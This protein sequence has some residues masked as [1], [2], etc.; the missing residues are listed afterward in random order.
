MNWLK[1]AGG[2][3][4]G[5]GSAARR[6][7][8]TVE[9]CEDRTL[10]A[11]FVVVNSDDS[12]D[13]S[14]RQA[15]LD[16]NEQ[17]G[18]D[19]ITFEAGLSAIQLAT[20][21]DAIT[22][23]VSINSTGVA[24]VAIDG[25]GGAFDGLTLAAGSGG[26]TI[27]LLTIRNLGGAAIRVQTDG[28]EIVGNT[29]GATAGAVA[30]GVLVDGGANNTIG[31]TG[32]G[33]ANVLGFATTAGV[34]LF[35]A[36][37][38]GNL[39]RGN[40]IGV[41]PAGEAIGNQ[42]GV[43]VFDAPG[44]TIG[45]AGGGNLIGNSAVAGVLIAGAGSTGNVVAA[46]AFGATVGG[47]AAPNAYGVQIN[48]ASGNT[49]G[50][51]GGLGN[52]ID[53]STSVG[54]QVFGAAATENAILG[55]AIGLRGTTDALRNGFGVEINAAGGNTVGGAA[56]G[57][58]NVVVLA[59]T[60]GVQVVG[61]TPS[62]NAVIG[63]FIG[64]DAT[65]S[66]GLGNTYG[67]L[68][69]NSNDNS[70]GGTAAGQGNTVGFNALAGVS[71]LTG[72]RNF[73]LNNRYVGPNGTAPTPDPAAD[74]NVGV[75]ANGGILPPSL[76]TASLEGAVLRL[77]FAADL[78]VGTT[79]QVYTLDA[80][81]PGRRAF[82]GSG[83]IQS[84]TEDQ[85][86]IPAGSLTDS[87]IVLVT[88]SGAST[89]TS[90]FSNTASVGDL[91]TVTTNVGTDAGSLPWVIA[92][93]NAG[94]GNEIRFD[95]DPG[96]RTI[97]VTAAAPL[98]AILAPVTTVVPAGVRISIQASGSTTLFNGLTLGPGSDGSVV[99]RM[100]FLGFGG[101]GLRVQSGTG[102]IRDVQFDGNGVGLL[103]EGAGNTA[104]GN[105][106]IRSSIAGVQ[107]N[108]LAATGNVIRGN[109]IGSPTDAALGNAV[110]VVI[111]GASG[112]T[113]GEAG[114]PNVIANNA[115]Q[116]VSI[117]AGDRNVVSENGYQSNGPA[118]G[119]SYSLAN[120]LVVAPGSNQ[121]IQP[122]LLL[123]ATQGLAGLSLLVELDT[124]FASPPIL[125]VYRITATTAEFL[126]RGP[127]GF[128]SG[129]GTASLA[130]TGVLPGDRLAVAV[131][132]DVQEEGTNLPGDATSA[133]SNQVIVVTPNVVVNTN[134]DGDGS[135]RGAVEY[136]SSLPPSADHR[137][138][139]R[140]P[141]ELKDPSGDWVIHLSSDIFVSGLAYIDGW[142][143]GES[144]EPLPGAF[145][146]P[147]VYVRP[148]FEGDRAE[149]GLLFLP[150]S[151]GSL[152]RGL[153]FQAFATAA[154]E[155][156][157][158]DVQVSGNVMTGALAGDGPPPTPA[159]IGVAITGGR[160][161]LVGGAAP[162]FQ[163]VLGGFAAAVMVTQGAGSNY[164]VGNQIGTNGFVD[165]RNYDGVLIFDSADNL[166]LNNLIGNSRYLAAPG[167]APPES[168]LRA[169]VRIVGAGATRNRVAGNSLGVVPFRDTEVRVGNDVGVYVGAPG[170]VIGSLI[171]AA[172]PVSG[173]QN[174]I[175]RNLH[176][177]L[178]SA[179]ATG[180]V[181]AGNYIGTDAFNRQLGNAFNGVWLRGASSNAVGVADEALANV[182]A[183]NSTGV[184]LDA[185]AASNA[186]ANNFIGTNRQ[187]LPMPNG[188][189]VL[190][191]EA[192]DTRVG[193][194][195]TSAPAL[196]WDPSGVLLLGA[197][198]ISGN[199]VGIRV[200]SV[201][202]AGNR[203]VG[204]LIG[205]YLGLPG[206]AGDGVD[207]IGIAGVTLGGAARPA[208]SG[209]APLTPG[210]AN[211]ISGNFDGVYVGPGAVGELIEGNWIFANRLNGVRVVSPMGGGVSIA[212]IRGN[213]IGTTF[214]GSSNRTAEGAPTGNGLS[215]VLM[216][217][218][219]SSP[220][221]GAWSVEVRGNLI[222]SNGLNGVTVDPSGGE[223][224]YAEGGEL[225]R[226]A[227]VLVAANTI[228]LSLAGAAAGGG[229][230]FGNVLDGV[231]IIGVGGV[232]VGEE[233]PAGGRRW[234]NVISGN[235]G[236]GVEVFWPAGAAPATSL[237]AVLIVGNLIGAG[238]EGTSAEGAAL[239][240][241]N[242][243][244][245]VFL[246][247][248]ARA[249]IRRNRIVGNRGAGVHAAGASE[250][251][252]GYLLI[253]ENEIG[254]D[255]A[256]ADLGNSADG[257]IVDRLA[258]PFAASGEVARI[259][260]NVI[261]ANRANGITVQAS[262]DVGVFGNLIGSIGLIAGSAAD[263][264]NLGNGVFLNGAIRATVGGAGDDG[265]VISG[266]QGN[267][268]VMSGGG[269]NELA[270]NHIGVGLDGISAVGN[271]NSGVLVS[272]SSGNG[273]GL[274]ADGQVVGNVVSGNRLYGVLIV[275]G[276][277]AAG[278]NFV[279]GNRVGVDRTG[280][281]A[282]PNSS[283]GLFL[284]NAA[285][286]IVGGPTAASRNIISGNDAQGVRVFG[287]A[288]TG[289][290]IGG[291]YIGVGA[292]GATRI[293]N[294]G[295]GLIL[296]NAGPNA[297]GL[298]RGALAGNVI[299]GNAQ[300]GI[301]VAST[302]G[303]ASGARIVANRI[304]LDA[305][306]STPVGNGGS[307]VVLAGAG[308]VVI[309]GVGPGERNWI[310]ANGQTGVVVSGPA[311]AGAPA[312]IL[313]NTIGLDGEGARPL[314][315]GGSGVQIVGA[316]GVEVGYNVVSA[317]AVDGVQVFS[318][319]ARSRADG[320]RIFGNFI[321]TNLAGTAALG[322]RGVGV[323]LVN[324]HGNLVGGPTPNVIS[325]NGAHGVAID[326]Q[327]G[328]GSEGVGNVVD[329]NLIGLDRGGSYRL[330]NGLYGVLLNN[331][332]GTVVGY[333][334][335]VP[336]LP[337]V[338]GTLVPAPGAAS[339]VISGNGAAGIVMTGS[340]QGTRVRG[341]YI[342]V[343]ALGR[344]YDDAGAGLDLYNRVGVLVE[345]RASGNWIGGLIDGEEGRPEGTGNLITQSASGPVGDLLGVQ[346]LSTEALANRVQA[347]LIGLDAQ[348]RSGS[349]AIG[350]LLS[351][352]RDVRI[353]GFREK[354]AGV[355]TYSPMGNVIS[356]NATAGVEIAGSLATG[357]LLV[358]NFIGTDPSGLGRPAP[359]TPSTSSPLY[360]PSQADGVLLAQA[361]GN[362]VGL[363]N[364]GNL[365]SGNGNGV[366]IASL[367]ANAPASSRNLIQGNTIGTDV[368]GL[369]A[370][371]NFGV[372]VFITAASENAIES[373]LISANGLAGIQIFGG[374]GQLGGSGT[375]A[376]LGN[377]ITGNRIGVDAN[378]RVAF[379]VSDGSRV[380]SPLSAHP[381]VTLPDGIVVRYGLQSHGVVIIGSSGNRV[382]L[383]GLGN[384]ISGNILTGVYISRRDNSLS[385]FAAPVDNVVQANNLDV[386]GIYGVFR[387]DAPNGN[388]VLE[389]PSAGANS[390]NGTPLPIGDFVTGLDTSTPGTQAQSILLVPAPSGS[391]GRPRR[392]Q[393][394]QATAPTRIATIPTRPVVSRPGL[395]QLARASRSV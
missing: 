24:G 346:V 116:G 30:Y 284:L 336:G 68:I 193:P 225:S 5:R 56:A 153:G 19:E 36:S 271:R 235:L 247:G 164:I 173:T 50:G 330:G 15:I 114:S 339:N 34:R 222:S 210:L 9:V 361:S 331:A 86:V 49:V 187:G 144:G 107:I 141:D 151:A 73:V 249:T 149:R 170:N 292:D 111:L 47:D 2:R 80:T 329:G 236:R 369:T 379:V 258:R 250:A 198:F 147:S 72:T 204:N 243:A 120:A 75:S 35:G 272:G 251:F 341:V 89:G 21:L 93:V 119:G 100:A 211:V 255:L 313:G 124:L 233:A 46:N 1:R 200:E 186:L 335:G 152:V 167:E 156:R 196:S 221:E 256:G 359:R 88:A 103:L 165:F 344:A 181:V 394:R 115:Q 238:L 318:P 349:N 8:P 230:P 366:D 108:G 260:R 324:G 84:G 112:N 242:L 11:T 104:S 14:L 199:F 226:Y 277:E 269:D 268:V 183:W 301:V 345:S 102:A 389:S 263:H 218:L 326:F 392:P 64:T 90:A 371:P 81:A 232:Q 91:L 150:G 129:T 282:V 13:G 207:L 273:I 201:L 356:G 283:D 307:G 215:G 85:L 244:D 174:V 188:S 288:S 105:V 275:G 101:S 126:G 172:G 42:H 352:A 310:S 253:E 333:A 365:I 110:G 69:F 3:R 252:R 57:E 264:G 4:A 10:L 32:P 259:V 58:A 308:G 98:P 59:R 163:N 41:G 145:I 162:N 370:L 306:G 220:A 395:A 254:T 65:L 166:V 208:T 136:V 128:S 317:N 122:A 139:F 20:A 314:G 319:E 240:T 67:V 206:N 194:A 351:N 161:S 168:E 217:P 22:D 309:G 202:G 60:A 266:N 113:V 257:V 262:T 160:G 357:N 97:L 372:G 191:A 142:D 388:P 44:N 237:T 293:G 245:G 189:G 117:L 354:L 52:A 127:A 23:P 109:T 12:G 132:G 287:T 175:G 99:E 155:V 54:V 364:A 106:F 205:A 185:G 294:Q 342:G 325:G 386:N 53:A 18:L 6:G 197:N 70:V 311:T 83:Q 43:Q 241:G 28:N 278:S 367:D 125:E 209:P 239:D 320:N 321:G 27:R 285:N 337:L 322:N 121:G 82:F 228:G 45:G 39:V 148:A 26:S 223:T 159:G 327:A 61:P 312:Q 203:I 332:V 393:G 362:T 7:R 380:I 171:G 224:T 305:S 291:N 178:L 385:L 138:Y 182:I 270:G 229:V 77:R 190:I 299:S 55:N 118:A 316:S 315:N 87:A 375:A 297:V 347:N 246:L 368:T 157:A 177:V 384:V 37:A 180:N 66:V 360:N 29:L 123:G 267:G 176:G 303:V 348:G 353:G 219:A 16:A 78:P 231:R 62:G 338:P 227:R 343:D 131:S 334:T 280:L 192:R 169:A 373:N 340:T 135:L 281:V 38:T 298:V 134:D 377:S 17:T 387:Y 33:E 154:V 290:W 304:G 234:S 184:R 296:D 76:A 390:F 31:G 289:N 295:N 381:E 355:G 350:V 248:D 363:I 214:D 216:T 79:V 140:I 143:T 279:V 133:F 212:T 25:G 376:S 95:L 51:A 63:N 302:V 40:L 358:N 276:R 323:D 71:V 146:E 130:I 179:A 378:G 300:S 374:R 48:N 383:P 382:G 158:D 328:R 213:F 94:L 96:E 195:S 265:N 92:N 286:N 137:I 274:D 261:G 391:P 74:I